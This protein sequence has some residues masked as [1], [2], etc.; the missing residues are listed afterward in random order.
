MIKRYLILGFLI[1]IIFSVGFNTTQPLNA[2]HG[3]RID[4]SI[5]NT[6]FDAFELEAVKEN[7]NEKVLLCQ[8]IMLLWEI[9]DKLY[10]EPRNDDL[11]IV[12]SS[13]TA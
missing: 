6:C 1:G 3:A 8:Q 7:I 13:L 2:D 12:F 5:Y 4:F 9:R 10:D 11:N